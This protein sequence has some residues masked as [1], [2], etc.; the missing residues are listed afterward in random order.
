MAFNSS[1]TKVVAVEDYPEV[2]VVITGTAGSPIIEGVLSIAVEN[3]KD[4]G[5]K[6]RADYVDFH[7]LLSKL[8]AGELQAVFFAFSIGVEPDHLYDFFHSG[9]AYNS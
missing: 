8:F 9:T 7:V 6:A 4:V 5:I 1:T 3:L 2:E